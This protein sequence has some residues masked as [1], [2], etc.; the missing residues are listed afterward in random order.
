MECKAITN[1]GTQCSRIAELGSKYCWQ[2]RNYD[3]KNNYFQNLPLLENTLL[4]YF[5]EDKP[6]KNINKQFTKLNY[7]KYSAKARRRQYT[8]PTSWY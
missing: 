8:Y 5:E 6:L 7:E 1:S 2:H 3:A 4:S